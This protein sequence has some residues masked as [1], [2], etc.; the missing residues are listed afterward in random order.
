MRISPQ[1]KLTT[2]KKKEEKEMQ[3]KKRER[4]KKKA[5]N[6]TTE[7]ETIKYVGLISHGFQHSTLQKQ[8]RQNYGPLFLRYGR[9]GGKH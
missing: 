7:A 4:K 5:T 3:E 8:V 1:D 6:R 9:S 2:P